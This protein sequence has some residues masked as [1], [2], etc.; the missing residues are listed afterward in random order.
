MKLY[1]AVQSTI[2]A[3]FG[4]LAIWVASANAQTELPSIK[5]QTA[6]LVTPATAVTYYN[7]LPVIHTPGL[8]AWASRPPEIQE[9]ARAL[10]ANRYTA[11]AYSASQN[12][13]QI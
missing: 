6:P 9:L 3:A 10:G 13:I 2:R 1:T 12:T 11:S 4:A 7:T 5:L 8:A